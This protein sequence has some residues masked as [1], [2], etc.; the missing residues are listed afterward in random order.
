M[1]SQTICE[2]PLRSL[3]NRLN[4]L[5]EVT[6]GHP[7]DLLVYYWIVRLQMAYNK[8]TMKAKL[9][10]N[11]LVFH[12]TTQKKTSRWNIIHLCKCRLHIAKVCKAKGF[13]SEI[14]TW[15]THVCYQWHLWKYWHFTKQ[16]TQ[17]NV[18]YLMPGTYLT[19]CLWA[20]IQNLVK[21]PFV[22]NIIKLFHQVINLY[23]PCQ[24][25][26]H[27]MCKFVTWCV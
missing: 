5:W 23:M 18:S 16:L 26:C 14:V 4:L 2:M 25:S 12:Y 17:L 21:I 9:P 27:G 6:H 1:S 22:L 7:L 8:A 20:Y 10:Q 19:T 11:R 15:W 3:K 24:L 13:S